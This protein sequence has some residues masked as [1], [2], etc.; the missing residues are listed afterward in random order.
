MSY[1]PSL[2]IQNKNNDENNLFITVITI[3]IRNFKCSTKFFHT[4][5]NEKHTEKLIVENTEQY[6]IRF[7]I[8]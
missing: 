1:K 8:I 6:I 4:F 5:E 2:K 3:A 7:K